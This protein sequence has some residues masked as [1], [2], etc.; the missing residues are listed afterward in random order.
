MKR[1][2]M[3][4]RLKAD[5]IQEY[6]KLHADVW[7]DVLETIAKANIKNYTIFLREPE[8]FLFGY[9]EYYGVDFEADSAKIAADPRTQEWWKITD[10]LQIR[11]E[12]INPNEQWSIME[13]VFHTD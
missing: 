10:S 1:M 13:E 7:P 9:W 5:K 6:K 4:I 3:V 12:S 11:M 8:N 2:G